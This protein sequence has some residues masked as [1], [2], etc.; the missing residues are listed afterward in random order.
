MPLTWDE[1]NS[2][3]DPGAFTIRTALDRMESMGY[4]PVLPAIELKPD[5]VQVLDRIAGLG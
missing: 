5:L 4:D 1:V 3:L 2:S